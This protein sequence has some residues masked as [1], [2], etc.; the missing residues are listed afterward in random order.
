MKSLLKVGLVVFSG[1]PLLFALSS[2]RTEQSPET[3]QSMVGAAVHD[4][5][6]DA[7]AIFDEKCAKC[8]G[9][10]GRAHS[11]H[12]KHVHARDLTDAKWQAEVSDERLFNSINNGRNKMPSFKNKLT[13]DQIDALVTYVRGLKH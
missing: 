9:K 12:G 11:L 8:H 5:S 10:D 4:S 1:C 2:T 3:S 13:E 6:V 7:R